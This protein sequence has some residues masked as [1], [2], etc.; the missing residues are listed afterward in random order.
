VSWGS[1]SVN[2]NLSRI[3]YMELKGKRIGN[4]E[5]GATL[6]GEE[7]LFAEPWGPLV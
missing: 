1:A 5:G 2:L 6:R 3:Q 7:R 4:E